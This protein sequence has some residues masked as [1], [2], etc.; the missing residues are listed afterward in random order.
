MHKGAIFP[1]FYLP[2]LE[3]FSQ[4][5]QPR[6]LVLME[7]YEHFQKQT[8]RNRAVIHSPQGKLALIVPVQKG[9]K[10]QIRM[11]DVKIS[12][13]FDWQRLH[14]RSLQTA[15]RSSAYFEFYEDD[16]SVFYHRRWNF[17]ADY[18]EELLGVILKLL[19][20]NIS[21]SYT[22]TY[23]E[24]YEDFEDFRNSIHPKKEGSAGFA[25]Y[26]Q[27]FEDRNGFQPNL[28]IVD[29]LFNQGP[30]SLAYL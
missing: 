1:I 25:H 4:M 30:Q 5:K 9:S 20:L 18:N 10:M 24:V 8:Y 14:W 28:S 23:R 6:E 26:F 2:P 21:F 15:Y 16:F 19:K 29:L 12:Y 13:D 17:L 27:V 3:F 22:E 7:R 11:K